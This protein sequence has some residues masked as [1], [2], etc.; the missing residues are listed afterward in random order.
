MFR[1]F[2]LFGVL[3]GASV[4]PAQ[5]QE[6]YDTQ[7]LF[8][9]GQWLVELTHD[10]QDGQL[11]CNGQTNNA[12]GQTFAITAYDSDQLV[13]FIFDDRWNIGE[14]PVRFLLDVDYSRWT[15]DGTG[16][17]IGVSLTMTDAEKAIKFLSELMEGNAVAVMNT[18]ER[19]LALFSLNGSFAAITKLFECWQG[20]STAG[21]FNSEDPFATDEDPF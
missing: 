5:A 14:R 13:L 20:I 6:R 9:K 1:N 3:L 18:N 19:R 21:S 11:W 7:T 16:A 10:T 12:Q 2:L 4:L 8:R 15:M 17:G